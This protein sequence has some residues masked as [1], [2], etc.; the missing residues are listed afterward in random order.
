MKAKKGDAVKV[1]YT[2][3]LTDGTVFDS[4]EGKDPLAF[5]IGQGQ[6]I[7][8]F[9]K[10]VEGMEVGA[11]KTINIPTKDAYGDIV[12]EAVV[13][14][15]VGQKLVLLNPQSG[16]PMPVTIIAA[17]NGKLTLDGN[18]PLAG[19]AL[20]F[21]LTLESVGEASDECCGGGSEECGCS[22]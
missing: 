22:H 16:E 10:G 15:P 1:H 18:H 4:S 3:K 21:E 17:E 14:I 12:K 7:P 11:T 8:G 5:V 19:K 20:T 9:E 2:G 6:I 13:E